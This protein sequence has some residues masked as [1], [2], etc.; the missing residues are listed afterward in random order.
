MEEPRR[1]ALIDILASDDDFS[2]IENANLEEMEEEI[3]K[4]LSLHNDGK[5]ADVTIRIHSV[6]ALRSTVEITVISLDEEPEKIE[7]SDFIDEVNDILL[8]KTMTSF[9]YVTLQVKNEH[10]CYIENELCLEEHN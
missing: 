5:N 9:A 3:T 8:T 1:I 6:I 2:Y 10:C 7:D 4:A